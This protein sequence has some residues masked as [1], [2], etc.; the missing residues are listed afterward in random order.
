M[1]TLYLKSSRYGRTIEDLSRAEFKRTICQQLISYWRTKGWSSTPQNLQ[2]TNVHVP[3]PSFKDRFECQFP[4]CTKKIGVFCSICKVPLCL[5]HFALH[6]TEEHKPTL[7]EEL[8][9]TKTK[10]RILSLR[11]KY[12]DIY[13]PDNLIQF[14]Q[15]NV[16]SLFG[17]KKSTNT[18]SRRKRSQSEME[19]AVAEVLEHPSVSEDESS[20]DLLRGNQSDTSFL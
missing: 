14:A 11:D 19:Y 18:G 13:T 1:P 16:S 2:L 17:M 8:A 10:A 6:L 5:C 4:G 20:Q 7:E 15:E 12:V 3:V 9:T